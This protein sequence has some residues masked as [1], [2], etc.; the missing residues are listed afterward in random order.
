[1]NTKNLKEEL[2][3]LVDELNDDVALE[4]FYK[5]MNYYKLQNSSIEIL[6]ELDSKQLARLLESIE[7]GKAG[8]TTSHLEMKKEIQQWFSR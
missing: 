2:H 4:N 1:M 5:A 3:K 7:Q 8:K 6:D